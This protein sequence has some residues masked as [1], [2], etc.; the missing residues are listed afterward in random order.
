MNARYPLAALGALVLLG[1]S[2]AHAADGPPRRVIEERPFGG[3]PPQKRSMG[4]PW[5]TSCKTP[6]LTCRL[7]KSKQV[8]STCS[9]PGSDGKDV[10]GVIQEPK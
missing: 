7:K 2:F 5:S 1:V 10:A 3:P 8:G 6:S 9:C 4:K